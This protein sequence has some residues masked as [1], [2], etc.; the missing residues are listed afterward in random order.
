M[1]PQG[2][3]HLLINMISL[4]PEAVRRSFWAR[5]WACAIDVLEL[6]AAESAFTS[7]EEGGRADVKENGN[8]ALADIVF[9]LMSSQYRPGERYTSACPHR[10][11]FA[12]IFKIVACITIRQVD[13]GATYMN[14]K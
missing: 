14:T 1:S 6:L 7:P 8:E 5:H 2:C 11:S 10:T 12:A 9:E 4:Q 13:H 3:S